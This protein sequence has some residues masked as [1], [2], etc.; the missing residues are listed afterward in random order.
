MS[1]ANA[2]PDSEAIPRHPD[3]TCADAVWL[4]GP[5][6][7]S[8]H[9]TLVDALQAA[10]ADGAELLTLHLKR[11]PE[12]LP[13]AL[14]LDR[15]SRWATRLTA[16]GVRRGEPVPLLLPTGSDFVTA[17][18]GVL[19]CGAVPVPLSSPMTFGGVD[20]Y[21]AN[22][23]RVV[24]DC[25]AQ[26]MVLTPRMAD[27]VRAHEA[28]S[29]QLDTLLLPSDVDGCEPSEPAPVQP[30]DTGLLQYTSG[31]TGDPKGARISHAALVANAYAIRQA[32]ELTQADVGVSWL[33]MFHDMGLIGVLLTNVCHPYRLH[34]LQPEAFVMRPE[35]WLDLMS[36][37][38]A[39]LTAGPNFAYALCVTRARPAADLDLS[40][41]R[42]ALNGSEP[43]HASTLRAFHDRYG[44]A[45]LGPHASLP[46]YG[47]AEATLAVA[48]PT[49]GRPVK[50]LLLDRESLESRGE[51]R[52]FV[53]GERSEA[54]SVG[55]PVVG[56]EVRVRRLNDVLASEDQVGEIEVGGTSLMDGY[57]GRPQATAEVLVDGWLRTGDLGFVHEGEL[58][59]IG[60]KK[61]VVIKGGRNIYPYD[62]ERVASDT[63]GTSA[64]AFGRSN[65]ETGTED[66]VLVVELR[67]SDPD[68]HAAI[69]KRLRG[70]LL[71]TL[72][73]KVDEVHIWP[74]GSL[75]RTTS[76]KI[77]RGACV[78]VLAKREAEGRLP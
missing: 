13:A 77:R 58:Y 38:G 23:V 30:S 8:P 61:E 65:A 67:G 72:G 26:R 16:A 51:V 52:P 14:L 57:H 1:P 47:M 55:T 60:R 33:P 29:A 22:L 53:S 12:A 31:T 49:V 24:A 44:E 17:F 62:V 34:L 74:L 36:E 2:Q 28:L 43:V 76:G 66:L 59:V 25:G 7:R 27:A 75:P 10:A 69:T 18:F 19:W 39:T 4:R 63:T 46:V 64:A 21:V 15:A 70:D 9:R 68:E 41:L 71:A 6:G 78:S 20:R 45:G 11:E 32:L 56:T 42:R 73:V 3:L 40:A 48:F 35:R 37:V 54:V 5:V 50:T